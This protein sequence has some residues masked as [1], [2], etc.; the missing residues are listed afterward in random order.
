V[1][2]SSQPNQSFNEGDSLERG[3]ILSSADAARAVNG[4][5]SATG[6]AITAAVRHALGPSIG[7]EVQVTGD[8]GDWHVGGEAASGLV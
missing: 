3:G 5:D 8:G 2:I 7:V 1:V 4:A 6:I